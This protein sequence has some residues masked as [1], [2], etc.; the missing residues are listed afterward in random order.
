MFH[1]RRNSMFASNI[2]KYYACV[3]IDI[4]KRRRNF[5]GKKKQK[6]LSIIIEKRQPF[7]QYSFYFIFWNLFPFFLISSCK[8]Q[9]KSRIISFVCLSKWRP[10]SLKTSFRVLLLNLIFLK[11]HI[12][13]SS[14]IFLE[15][16][17]WQSSLFYTQLLYSLFSIC[18][19]LLYFF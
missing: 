14:S 4:I 2:C 8:L 7:S 12:L 5:L 16:S 13:K 1:R 18:L 19:V 15:Y 6:Q 11:S 3:S 9:F 10:C 17:I